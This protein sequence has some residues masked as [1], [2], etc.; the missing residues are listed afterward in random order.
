MKIAKHKL[1]L[2][3]I[4]NLFF[5]I[6]N[7]NIIQASDINYN[8]MNFF[9]KSYII[10][11]FSL[12]T[13]LYNLIDIGIDKKNID[14]FASLSNNIF[15]QNKNNIKIELLKGFLNN[16]NHIKIGKFNELDESILIEPFC[17]ISNL[18]KNVDKLLED[19]YINLYEQL[20]Q[21]K[22]S[23]AVVVHSKNE[24]KNSLY[25]IDLEEI[26]IPKESKEKK[27][28][29]NELLCSE[30]YEKMGTADFMN[31]SKKSGNL[32][33]MISSQQI[34]DSKLTLQRAE[35]SDSTHELDLIKDSEKTEV[36][37]NKIIKKQYSCPNLIK[38]T[39]LLQNTLYKTESSLD[40]LT[41]P[42]LEARRNIFN[43]FNQLDMDTLKTIEILKIKYK[44]PLSNNSQENVKLLDTDIFLVYVNFFIYIENIGK[45]IKNLFSSFFLIDDNNLDNFH[46]YINNI[47]FNKLNSNQLYKY[48]SIGYKKYRLCFLN[49]NFNEISY[50]FYSL[51]YKLNQFY[52]IGIAFGIE[53]IYI[54]NNI[55]FKDSDLSLSIFQN[56]HFFPCY[57]SFMLKTHFKLIDFGIFFY[58]L[59]NVAFNSL[60]KDN[61]LNINDSRFN[62]ENT[63]N[64]L[65]RITFQFNKSFQPE[66]FKNIKLKYVYCAVNINYNLTNNS[67]NISSFKKQYDILCT[68][69]FSYDYCFEIFYKYNYLFNTN[70][71]LK[72]FFNLVFDSKIA[73]Q[74]FNQFVF[75]KHIAEINSKNLNSTTSLKKNSLNYNFGLNIKLLKEL[76]FKIEF[77]FNLK[78]NKFIAFDF[79]FNYLF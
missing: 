29:A 51:L 67:Y 47:D 6:N 42:E 30:V 68:N 22:I 45:I 76:L 32:K 59:K 9:T 52:T 24:T 72:L 39:S 28:E 78:D 63:H 4:I 37:Y 66:F 41:F 17:E 1:L 3:I 74:K 11:E 14:N 69:Y 75:L 34:E 64:L 73:I 26:P 44:I 5:L 46:S 15:W 77:K 38:A 12:I 58:L 18:I 19:D 40:L 21:A 65:T 79:S 48:T 16:F 43:S 60:S 2:I 36:V 35:E 62:L 10:K 61:S 20:K 71:N 33:T 56:F 55:A 70:I 50:I 25:N 53:N 27:Y 13:H 23:L 7:Y 49:E 57:F 31:F 54:K 8:K